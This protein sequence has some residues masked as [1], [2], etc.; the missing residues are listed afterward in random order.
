MLTFINTDYSHNVYFSCIFACKLIYL[1]ILITQSMF[2]NCLDCKRF[3][4]CESRPL[5]SIFYCECDCDF[6][7]SKN[8]VD[9]VDTVE[10]GKVIV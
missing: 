4:A 8:F 7:S 10:G 6:F 9:H 2:E 3:D 1:L 5:Y